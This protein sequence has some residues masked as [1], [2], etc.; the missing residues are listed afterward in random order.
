[1]SLP[2]CFYTSLLVVV[3]TI[4]LPLLSV[5][6]KTSVSCVSHTTCGSARGCSLPLSTEQ[7]NR[8]WNKGL[9]KYFTTG[10]LKPMKMQ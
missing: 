2:F 5:N 3:W 4:V 6:I 8:W 1:M 10:K 7:A 9:S